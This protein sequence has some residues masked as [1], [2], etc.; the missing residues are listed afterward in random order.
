MRKKISVPTLRR[1]PRYYRIV[2]EHLER[3]GEYIRSSE[4]AFKLDVDE[5]QVRK[6]I[7]AINYSGKPKIGFNAREF[8]AHLEK[9]L[10][11]TKAKKALLIGVGNLGLALAKYN[12]FKKYGLD[13]VA[14]FDIDPQKIGLKV[15]DKEVYHVSRLREKASE[16]GIKVAILAI[17]EEQAQKMADMAV[18]GGVKAIWN[19]APTFIEVPDGIIVSNQDLAADFVVLSMKLNGQQV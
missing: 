2:C 19:F 18:A 1:L 17:P 7:S 13:I 16:M 6:D 4:I 3:G 15:G 5:T 11:L 12:G 9:F 8:K 14:L 10:N